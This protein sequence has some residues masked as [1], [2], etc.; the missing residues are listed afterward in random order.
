[1]Y[2]FLLLCYSLVLVIL[3]LLFSPIFVVILFLLS[4]H[5]SPIILIRLGM[6][7]IAEYGEDIVRLFEKGYNV[8]YII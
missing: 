1:M 7:Y 2:A 3:L 4:V 8:S 5:F 6:Y